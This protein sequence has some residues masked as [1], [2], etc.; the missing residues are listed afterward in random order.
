M[1]TLISSPDSQTQ[2]EPVD[3]L[4]SPIQINTLPYSTHTVSSPQ[5][6]TSHSSLSD[7]PYSSSSN[8]HENVNQSLTCR[9]N[10]TNQHP[11]VT[12]AKVGTFKPKPIFSYCAKTEIELTTVEV[13]LTN[14]KWKKAMN[15]EYEALMKNNT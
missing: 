1:I 10:Q 5:T 14:Q 8:A 3:E 2:N 11:M 4:S 7:T 15:E 9:E 6:Q 12:R 13:A